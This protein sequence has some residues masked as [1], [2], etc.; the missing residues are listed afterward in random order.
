MLRALESAPR[1]V[2]MLSD[3]SEIFRLQRRFDDAERI[4][5][6][7]AAI[8]PS[9][10]RI[11]LLRFR[12]FMNSGD[13]AGARVFLQGSGHHVPS[14]IRALLGAE[15][16]MVSR[17]QERAMSGYQ[18][19]LT[20]FGGGAQYRSLTLAIVAAAFGDSATARIHA[21]SMIREARAELA[22]RD[23][24]V[25]PFHARAQVESQIAVAM[26]IRGEREP[27]VRLGEA[28]VGEFG[29]EQ[30]AVDGIVTLNNLALTYTIAGRRAEAVSALRRALTTPGSM[31]RA[32][33]ALDPRWDSLRS[34]PGFQ[35]LL[36][37][38]D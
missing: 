11:A 13:T 10:A 7:A 18:S 37:A 8:E 16:A 22:K 19:Q 30:D 17:D 31:T 27:A 38:P 14:R 21:D 34:D 4:L 12:G 6:R 28:S 2:S 9:S 23:V 25:D 26:A 33:L 3:L 32:F 1:D 36:A 5:D 20:Q 24:G 29:P 35:Q 15:L